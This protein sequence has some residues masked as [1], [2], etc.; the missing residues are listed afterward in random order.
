MNKPFLLRSPRRALLSALLLALPLA[1]P[2]S[3]ALAQAPA[4]QVAATAAADSPS[5]LVRAQ[6]DRILKTLVQR[7]EE[8]RADPSALHVYVDSA[9]RDLFDREYS[10]R[11]VL[12]QHSR[13]ATADAVRRFADALTENLMRRY[14]DALLEVDPKINVRVKGETPLRGGAIVRVATEIERQGGAPVPVDYLFRDTEHG[15]KVFDVI[16][17][18]VS[19]V[20]T[21]RT[22]FGEQLRSRSLAQVTEELEQGRLALDD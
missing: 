10:A 17:E 15:W 7:R 13:G 4:A 19:Y 9:L 1:A 3:A 14:G 22:Q 18:G 21:Y 2:L 6:S 16:V 20:Q 5:A 8:F 12:A 11:L